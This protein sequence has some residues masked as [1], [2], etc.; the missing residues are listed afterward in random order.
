MLHTIRKHFPDFF[1]AAAVLAT[2]PPAPESPP[3]AEGNAARSLDPDAI[4]MILDEIDDAGLAKQ[5]DK[6]I[7][8]RS[9]FYREA[10]AAGASGVTESGTFPPVSATCWRR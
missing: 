2:Q 4:R 10:E 8:C 6:R 3:C 1:P 5:A 9:P 7:E